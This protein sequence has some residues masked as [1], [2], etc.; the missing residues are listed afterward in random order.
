M[1]KK[2]IWKAKTE[3]KP[4]F[5]GLNSNVFRLGFGM[6]GG[7]GYSGNP[8]PIAALLW[9]ILFIG[10]SGGIMSI[11]FPIVIVLLYILAWLGFL[12]YW[13]V[14]REI[15][16]YQ[17]AKHTSYKLY[18]DELIIENKYFGKL[19]ETKIPIQEISN[20]HLVKY[21]DDEKLKGSIWIYTKE[22]FRSFDL[23][24]RE[25]NNIP[26]IELVSDYKSIVASLKRLIIQN[27][28]M[29]N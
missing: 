8:G 23:Y 3:V 9:G 1:E 29:V 4:N 19:K 25:R 10:M 22:D 6:V 15:K 5:W 28:K 7:Y 20:I 24:K 11:F 27:K 26:K 2:L 17:L 16:Y 18:E 13:F 21:E 12:I 14:I